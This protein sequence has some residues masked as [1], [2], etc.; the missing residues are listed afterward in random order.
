MAVGTDQW[1]HNS[2]DIVSRVSVLS[3]CCNPVKPL[4]IILRILNYKSY[5]G[6]EIKTKSLA[7]T[8]I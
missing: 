8:S 2:V 1:N 7:K 3:V 4:L 6:G 5:G